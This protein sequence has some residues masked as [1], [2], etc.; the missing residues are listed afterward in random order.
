MWKHIDEE[1]EGLPMVTKTICKFTI[2]NILTIPH[3][4][5]LVYVAWAYFS[6]DDDQDSE[7]VRSLLG[8]LWVLGIDALLFNLIE[9]AQLQDEPSG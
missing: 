9:I 1:V 6:A 5:A 8:C 4:M 3:N 2:T 7:D